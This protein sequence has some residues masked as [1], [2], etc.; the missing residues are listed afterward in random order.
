[1]GLEQECM[2][3]VPKQPNLLPQTRLHKLSGIV[4]QRK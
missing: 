1:M 4:K 3:L 2:E